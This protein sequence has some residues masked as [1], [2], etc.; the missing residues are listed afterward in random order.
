MPNNNVDIELLGGLSDDSY[1]EIL[2]DIKNIQKR[3]Q[4]SGIKINIDADFDMLIQ[5]LTKGFTDSIKKVNIGRT[6]IDQF[7][8]VDKTAQ[9]KIRELGKQLKEIR[10]GEMQTGVGDERLTSVMKELG[11]VVLNNANIIE[12]RMGIYD[13]FYNYLKKIGS[14]KISD[15]VKADLGDDWNTLRQLYPSKFSTTKGIE[16]ESIYQEMSSKF[17]N[18]FTGVANPA[19]QFREITDAIRKYRED[20]NKIKALDASDIGLEDSVFESIIAEMER[21]YAAFKGNG[22]KESV[23][24]IKAEA[25][26]LEKVSDS[27]KVA[28]DEKLAFV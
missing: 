25:N 8:V 18:L 23:S 1:L 26:A 20:V 17:S 11:D 28:A 2:K 24:E 9:A 4:A 7:G 16:L 6:L 22:I 15:A 12:Q 27:A 5:N 21:L 10:I 13:E 19:D 14:I 3:L